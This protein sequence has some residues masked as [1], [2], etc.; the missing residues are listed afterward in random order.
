MRYSPMPVQLDTV[1][2]TLRQWTESDIDAHRA[3]VAERGGGMPSIEDNRRMIEG[4]RAASARTG[5]ALLPVI[6]RDVGDFIGYCGLTVGRASVDE[7][8]IA[9]ELFQRVHGQGYA[10]EAASAVLDAARATGRTRLWSTVRPWNLPSFRVLEKLGFQ[11][12][13]I[14]TDDSGELVWLTRPLP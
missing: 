13:H 12:D 2:L 10:T 14:S 6:R 8:E 11:R 7:P 5:I 1:R 4:Q 3:L 9:Y